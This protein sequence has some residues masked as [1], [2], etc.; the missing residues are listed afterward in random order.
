LFDTENMN[1]SIQKYHPRKA[2]AWNDFIER[3]SNGTFLHNRNYMDYHARRFDDASLMIYDGEKL[4]AVLPAHRINNFLYAHNGLTYSDFIFHFKLKLEHKIAI[5]QTV[6]AYLQ[7]NG[8]THLQ[9]KSIP[10]VFT[11]IIDQS[12]EY[13]YQQLQARLLMLK[14]F[15]VRFRNNAVK[16]NRNRIKNFKK[17]SQ[18][19]YQWE[20]N[21]AGLEAF[22]KIV[23]NNL[24]ER[25]NSNPIHTFE[26]MQL[27][28]KRF[29]DKI[30]LFTVK[31]NQN[32]LAGALVYY[33]NRA[34]H[35]QYI[36]SVT[37]NEEREA[38]EWLIYE[39]LKHHEHQQYIS[40]GTSAVEE[41]NLNKG[42]VYWKQSWG[43][44]LINQSIY[45]IPTRHHS[46][47]KNILQ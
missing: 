47:L 38:V 19:A 32:I 28:M 40:F 46:L 11:R 14:P 30:K 39:I 27:L 22:W 5:V 6:L 8:I 36:H 4:K 42:L 43:C 29:P 31:E 15:F 2:Q 12:N 3:S 21:P 45:E 7:A 24:Q 23:E 13:I 18:K 34:M 10:F 44:T 37:H 41:N 35:F 16:I 25:Y 33:I 17:M 26:E 9:V 20:E 1:Y